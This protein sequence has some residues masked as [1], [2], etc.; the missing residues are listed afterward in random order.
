[1]DRQDVPEFSGGSKR[2]SVA[3]MSLNKR[4]NKCCCWPEGVTYSRCER[5]GTASV[6]AGFIRKLAS[7]ANRNTVRCHGLA[8][9][10]DSPDS[11]TKTHKSRVLRRELR[12]QIARL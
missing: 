4:T 10:S 9:G 7:S 12:H 2:S 6:R 3:A 5:V 1:M 11:V 8:A